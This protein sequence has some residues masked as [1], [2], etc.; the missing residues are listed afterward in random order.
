MMIFGCGDIAI[1]D[2]CD[3]DADPFKKSFSRL[4]QDFEAAG[5]EDHLGGSFQFTVQEVEVFKVILINDSKTPV[6]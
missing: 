3:T 2:A 1:C 6:E 4:G 5:Q